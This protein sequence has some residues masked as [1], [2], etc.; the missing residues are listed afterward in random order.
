MLMPHCLKKKKIYGLITK[1]GFLP[2]KWVYTLLICLKVNPIRNAI[3]NVPIL[4]A[5][6]MFE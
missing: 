1:L 2:V 5:A 3:T 6:N 4:T